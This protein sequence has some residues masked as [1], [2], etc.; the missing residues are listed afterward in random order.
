MSFLAP[1]FFL[2]T[3]AIVGPI[4]FHLIRR[5]TR[6][7]TPFSTLMFL[8]A[9]PPR[10]TRRSR[11]ENLW[12]LLLRCLA[13]GLLAL[14]FA[15]PLL[16]DRAEQQTPPPGSSKRIVVLIDS[17]ASMKRE[18][19]WN[20]AKAKAETVAKGAGASDEVAIVL[21]DRKPRVLV[22]FSAW[23][24]ELPEARAP[25]VSRLLKEQDA[26]W[27]AT[28]LDAA[29][30][31]AADL[32]DEPSKTGAPTP[33]LR[34]IILISDLQEGAHIDS[35]QGFEWPQNVEVKIE[36]LKPSTPANAGLAWVTEADDS[37]ATPQDA[38]IFRLR[39]TNSADSKK[40][41]FKLRWIGGA[42]PLE[43][44]AY[45]PAGQTRIVRAP[46]S[47]SGAD[48]VVLVPHEA[49]PDFDNTVFILSPPPIRMPILFA[50]A[51]T[52]IDPRGSRYYLERAFQ[53]AGRQYA[54]IAPVP[55]N[56]P[57]PPEQ[58]DQSQ[59]LIVGHG[60]GDAVLES[61][62]A[63]ARKGRIVL[64]PLSDA[65]QAVLLAR[66]LETSSIPATEAEVRDYG[67][68]AELNLQDPLL[69]PFADP[70]FSDF[71]KIHFWHY[72]RIDLASLPTAKVVARFDD[73]S[74][75]IA[76]VPLGSGSV[77]ILATTWRPA[78]SQLALSSKFV[79]LLFSMLEQS[80]HVPIPRAQYFVGDEGAP[81][82]KPGIFH[83]QPSA[84]R[85]AVNLSPDESRTAPLSPDHLASLGVPLH[86][87]PAS[88]KVD[89]K[90]I[91]EVRATELE[92]RQKLWRWILATCLGVLLI[93]TL[94]AGRL[95]RPALTTA[96]PAA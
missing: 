81:G 95:S 68:L 15:R 18:G 29:L 69:S 38:P 56:A 26:G 71:T 92:S 88:V 90:R 11:L 22:N 31:H 19:L 87:D 67:L 4:I 37:S 13:V 94:L 17:S 47:P 66:L 41:Q 35:L 52:A 24:A 49:D 63:F 50:G 80:S 82:D 55:A 33:G 70:R 78:D 62:R 73:G 25:L 16:R 28:Y 42:Q 10:V 32:L 58:L 93:E 27:G 86:R 85:V 6:E 91:A 53:K 79:P 54:E 74:P 43:F 77:I 61:V 23:T 5:T 72:R 14:A 96:E 12:L 7:R 9:T 36:H 2:G 83:I 89:P 65:G 57:I 30:T 21:F 1:L 34:E 46:K 60:A 44:D 84:V 59:L 48:R 75:A 51:D 8:Q 76:R 39:V 45:V 40:D 20:A 64:F 3:L